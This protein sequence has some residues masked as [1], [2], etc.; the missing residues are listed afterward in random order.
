MVNQ[1]Q[2]IC[3]LRELVDRGMRFPLKEHE[4][5]TCASKQLC[6]VTQETVLKLDKIYFSQLLACFQTF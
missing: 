3:K 4:N 6:F 2:G 5:V 1:R